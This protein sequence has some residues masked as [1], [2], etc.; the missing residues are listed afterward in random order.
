MFHPYAVML[1]LVPEDESPLKGPK[2]DHFFSN[3]GPKRDQFF[4]KKGPNDYTEKNTER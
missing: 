2:R 1:I 3:K 4:S